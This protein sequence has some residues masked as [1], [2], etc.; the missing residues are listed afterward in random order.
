MRNRVI[1]LLMVAGLIVFCWWLGAYIGIIVSFFWAVFLCLFL[2]RDSSWTHDDDDED[3]SIREEQRNLG[4][5]PFSHM[6]PV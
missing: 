1:Y 4:V 2:H 5:G 6:P 3:Q